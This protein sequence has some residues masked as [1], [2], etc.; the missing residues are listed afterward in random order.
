MSNLEIQGPVGL[1]AKLTNVSSDA[2]MHF[3]LIIL[4]LGL[5][6]MIYN[7]ENERLLFRKDMYR[8][9][10]E[11]INNNKII[12]TDQNII[13]KSITDVNEEQKAT[14]YVLTLDEQQ[15]KALKLDM[16]I[17]LRNRLSK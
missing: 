17:V 6:Y 12:Q 1:R 16:P 4:M 3:I 8:S 14:T 10:Q 9:I 15:R 7:G 5:M 2:V 13:L 11:Q